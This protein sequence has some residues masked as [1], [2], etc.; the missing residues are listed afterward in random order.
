MSKHWEEMA[1]R[2][3]QSRPRLRRIHKTPQA[4]IRYWTVVWD[5]EWEEYRVRQY[6]NNVVREEFDYFTTDIDDAFATADA[7]YEGE[8]SLIKNDPLYGRFDI[9]A[10]I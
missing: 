1:E 3:S 4:G 6:T 2:M 5:S 7:M 10:Q 8:L 9:L